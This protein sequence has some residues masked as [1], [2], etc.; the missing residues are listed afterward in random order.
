MRSVPLLNRVLERHLMPLMS[1]PLD[2]RARTED[3]INA[4][5]DQDQWD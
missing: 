3:E 5:L 2:S 1:C 4:G